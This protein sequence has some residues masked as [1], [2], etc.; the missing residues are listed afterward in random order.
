MK[1]KYVSRLLA[2]CLTV[3]MLT[4]TG[5]LAS[6]PQPVVTQEVFQVAGQENETENK[7]QAEE[8]AADSAA[9]VQTDETEAAENRTAADKSREQAEPQT[10][11]TGE[12]AEP[13]TAQTGEQ[14]ASEVEPQAQVQPRAVV[15]VNQW[16]RNG[17]RWWYRHADGSYTTNGW[18]VINGAWYYFDG[19]GWMVTGWL[20]RPSGWYY[21]T[22]SGAMATGWIQLGSTWYYLN[23]SGTMQADTWIG[24]NY[25]DG[26]GA[27]IPGKVKAQ[28]G[29]V[30][31][32]SRWWYRHAD[33]SYTTNGW[34][35]INGAWYYFD[36]AGWMVT[37]WVKLSGTWY[38]LTGSGAMATGW[39]QV[40]G[41]WYYMNTSGAMVTD[42]WIGNNYVDGSGAWIPGKVKAQ[43]GW[44]QSGNRWWYRHADGSYTKN[45]WEAINGTW[46]YF[47]GAGWMVTGWIKL[48]ETWYYL[49]GSGV[50]AT[51]WIQVGGTWYYMNASGAMVT[52]TWIGDNY[53]DG[54]GAWV[55]GKTR[56]QAYW[57]QNNGGWLY[58]QENGSYAKSTWKT[59]DGKEY[60]F[61]ADSYMVTGWL[62]QGSTWYYLKPT[63]KN[64]AE[65]VGEKAYNY[66]VGTAG[67]GGYYIDKYGRMVA[68]KDY[69]LGSYVYTFDANGLCTNR[70]NRYLQVTD[71]NG[72]KY[73]VEKKTYLSDP[74]VGA[75]VTEDEFLAAA[76]YAESA[77]Q[78]LTGMT[79]VA[80][81]MLNR[82]RT[83][84]TSTAPYPSEAK[85][86]IYQ[87][88]QFEVARDGALTRSLNLIVSGKGGTAM[89]NAKKAVAN[90]RAICDA[91]DNNKT[92]ELSDE[93]KGILE[94]LK[95][96]EGHTMLEYLGFMTPKAFENANLDPEKTHA[97][98]Y[99]NTTFYS[100]W[101]KK[102]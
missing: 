11:Q 5:A 71:A 67:I 48:S 83:N 15:A 69:S 82:M 94:E 35:V 73:N 27:W 77:N 51:G 99:K 41:T 84:K 66:W 74:Q 32:G 50:M 100:T 8:Y 45:N 97:F 38:Y 68:G 21:L 17:N 88:T 33:G 46:Y 22:G 62:K 78:G 70:E 57:V 52:D 96:P 102:S 87:A 2:G 34:E 20:K 28:A 47:D 61:G 76:V 95:V 44:I 10:A 18:E 92:D 54:S 80:M 3:T 85:N 7:E 6:V 30:Q 14:A 37:G 89:E 31:S 16:I 59:I 29:W 55:Q 26:S 25:V 24:N 13:Q 98:T 1:K 19:A 23:E 49:T 36:G 40:G 64:S 65:K 53:V 90:A 91:Y 12:Q 43:A 4:P 63:A 93:V 72:R 56:A 58:V 79:G 86:M 39:I 75:D 81:V 60:Y 101:I 9:E 42:T